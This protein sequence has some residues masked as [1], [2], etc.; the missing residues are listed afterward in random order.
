MQVMVAEKESVFTWDKR[1]ANL[2][3]HRGSLLKHIHT[4]QQVIVVNM[5]MYVYEHIKNN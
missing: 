3:N 1:S 5:Y 4:I 2:S